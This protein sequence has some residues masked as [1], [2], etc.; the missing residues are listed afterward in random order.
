MI[1]R[2]ELQIRENALIPCPWDADDRWDFELEDVYDAI[3]PL[4]VCLSRPRIF[5]AV[6]SLVNRQ[7]PF[8][9]DNAHL[10]LMFVLN[11]PEAL[12]GNAGLLESDDYIALR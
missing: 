8:K 5:M 11:P 7:G 10:A 4:L 12:F 9:A 6:S 3:H 1:R 2:T